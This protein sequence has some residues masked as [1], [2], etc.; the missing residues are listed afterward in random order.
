MTI[1][2]IITGTQPTGDLR[3][4][5]QVDEDELDAVGL[6]MVLDHLGVE[7]VRIMAGPNSEYLLWIGVVDEP[8]QHI[9]VRWATEVEVRGHFLDDAEDD[10]DADEV[11]DNVEQYTHPSVFTG[12]Y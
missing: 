9:L 8:D 3:V 11:E 1:E 12:Q 10:D 5:C 4:D 6:D 2:A 7:E